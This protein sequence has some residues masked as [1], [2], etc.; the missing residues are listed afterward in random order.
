MDELWRALRKLNLVEL[1]LLLRFA[2]FLKEQ[3][4]KTGT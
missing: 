1:R 4:K 2:E 3:A